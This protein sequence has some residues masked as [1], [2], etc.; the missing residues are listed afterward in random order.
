MKKTSYFVVGIA[1]LIILF[2]VSFSFPAKTQASDVDFYIG[3]GLPL[4]PVRVVAPPQVFLIPQTPVYYAPY[5]ETPLFFYAGYWYRPFDGC[6]HRGVSYS[7]PWHHIH[8]RYVPTVIHKLPS[9]YYHKH[10]VYDRKRYH[11]K[12]GNRWEKVKYQ[13]YYY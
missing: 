5:F 6:W 4:P 11:K 13:K 12:H 10:K 1:S 2:A 3:I 7:G 8:H 9:H